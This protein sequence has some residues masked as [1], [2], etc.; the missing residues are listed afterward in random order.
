[1]LPRGARIAGQFPDTIEATVA[2]PAEDVANDVRKQ[3]DGPADAVIGPNGTVFPTLRVK[4]AD[5]GHHLHVT[6]GSEEGRTTLSVLRVEER[7]PPEP[8]PPAEAMK[9]AGLNPDGT[10][11]HPE[12]R[13]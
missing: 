10:L 3:A 1:M 12:L 11:L 6:I 9:K 5:P 13:Q 8:E 4:G 2:L 7:P